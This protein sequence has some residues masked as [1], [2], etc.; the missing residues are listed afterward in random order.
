MRFSA[1]LARKHVTSRGCPTTLTRAAYPP[2]ASSGSLNASIPAFGSR[3]SLHA[4]W[5]AAQPE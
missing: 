2:G 5:T 4:L 3:R 1:D